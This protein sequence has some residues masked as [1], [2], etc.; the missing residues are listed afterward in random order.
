MQAIPDSRLTVQLTMTHECA[1]DQ[2]RLWQGL[3]M[4]Y[5]CGSVQVWRL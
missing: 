4:D 1:Y 5:L 3:V 2:H